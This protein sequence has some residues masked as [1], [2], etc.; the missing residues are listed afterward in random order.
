M[1][2]ETASPDHARLAVV[3][4]GGFVRAACLTPRHRAGG[5]PR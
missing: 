4:G 1:V 5:N 2:H 3:E